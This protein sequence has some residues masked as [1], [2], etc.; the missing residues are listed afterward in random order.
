MKDQPTG[1]RRA[2]RFFYI[3]TTSVAKHDIGSLAAVIAFYAFF[4]LFPL[5]LLAIYTL[6]VA[7][8]HSSTESLLM[9]ILRPYFPAVNSAEDI[10]SSNLTQLAAGRDVGLVSAVTL[11]WSATSGFIAL[12]Q[13][14]DTIYDTEQQRS[15]V[16]RRLVG[17]T[18]LLILLILTLGSAIV[19]GVSPV[20]YANPLMQ[21]G[22]LKWFV[23]VHGLSRIIFPLSLI[24]GFIISF[25]YLPSRRIEWVYL[26]PGALVSALA[27]DVGRQGFVWYV[28]HIS[29]YQMIYGTLT[30]VMLLVLWMYIGSILV[31]F[32]AEVSAALEA[33]LKSDSEKS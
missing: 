2:M 1:M 9:E 27:L 15:F 5:L 12:Q 18:M 33:V 20:F 32:G 31:L 8:P 19:L 23:P 6:S 7:F 29:R 3:L 28:T 4:S 10:I 13:A 16:A 24:L 22:V 30:T 25:R 14:L 17:F 11:L 26:F 21:S